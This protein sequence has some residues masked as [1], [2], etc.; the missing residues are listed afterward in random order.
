VLFV[1]CIDIALYLGGQIPPKL[2]L[3]GGA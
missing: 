1:G 2:H 3:E